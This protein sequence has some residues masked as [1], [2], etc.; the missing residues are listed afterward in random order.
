MEK[1]QFWLELFGVIVWP[2][3]CTIAIGVAAWFFSPL[4]KARFLDVTKVSYGSLSLEFEK[5]LAIQEGVQQQGQKVQLYDAH[6]SPVVNEDK[7]IIFNDLNIRNLSIEDQKQ[8]L[9][10][11]LAHNRV[12]NHY[13]WITNNI[14]IEQIQCLKQL[15]N[16]IP[17]SK[18]Q[19]RSFY[20]NYDKNPKSIKPLRTFEQFI[21]WLSSIHLIT[22]NADANYFITDKGLDYLRFLLSIGHPIMSS[23]NNIS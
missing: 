13:W 2:L 6:A 9:I 16:R 14:F 20:E 19:M 7:K 4:I 1:Y 12:Y 18:E 5:P 3:F 21:A 15:N 8:L 10:N 11:D 23:N 22:E 17:L